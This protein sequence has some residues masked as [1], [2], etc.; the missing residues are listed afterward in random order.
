MARPDARAVAGYYAAPC[1]VAESCARMVGHAVDMA[2]G[3]VA[4]RVKASW[5]MVDPCAANGEAALTLL[6]ALCGPDLKGRSGAIERLYACEL[7]E[8]RHTALVQACGAAFGYG[9]QGRLLHGDAFRVRC[10]VDDTNV[11]ASILWLNP[12]YDQRRGGV[13]PES[14]WLDRWT[15]SLVLGGILFF[16]VPHKALAAC[17]ATLATHYDRL[18]CFRFPDATFPLFGQ[19]VVVGVRRAALPRP[20]P[21]V[22]AMVGRWADDPSALCD[23]LQAPAGAYPLRVVGD[24]DK[25]SDGDELNAGF[26][27]WELRGL[28]LATVVTHFTPWRSRDR[29]GVETFMRGVLPETGVAGLRT[30]TFSTAMPLCE[31][32]VAAALACN[33]YDGV[34]LTPNTPG[35]GKPPVFAKATGTRVWAET[36]ARQNDDGEDVAIERVQQPHLAITALDTRAGRIIRFPSTIDEQSTDDIGAMSAAD[37]VR[38]YSQA[39][40]R[41]LGERCVALYDP[42]NEAHKTERP[43]VARPLFAAQEDRAMACVRLLDTHRCALLLGATGTG[44]T[45][46]AAGVISALAARPVSTRRKRTGA[47]RRVLVVCPP[48]LL[49]SWTSELAIVAPHVRS[50]V[51]DSI[52]AAE[53]FARDPGPIVGIVA[54]TMSKLEHARAGFGEKVPFTM[55]GDGHGS[56][57]GSEHRDTFQHGDKRARETRERHGRHLAGRPCARCGAEPTLNPGDLANKRA[58][59]KATTLDARNEA[60]RLALLLIDAL[61]PVWPD[62]AEIVTHI[63]VQHRHRQRILGAWE[64]AALSTKKPVARQA[65]WIDRRK[66]PVLRAIVLRLTR[67]LIRAGGDAPKVQAALYAL[68]VGLADDALTSDAACRLWY[69]AACEPYAHRAQRLRDVVRGV[70]LLMTPCSEAQAMLAVSLASSVQ[71]ESPPCAVTG[72]GGWRS[73]A[74]KASA[75]AGAAPMMIEWWDRHHED[76][77]FSAWT[78]K[79]GAPCYDGLPFGSAKHGLNALTHLLAVARFTESAPCDEPL[80]QSIPQPRR[81]PLG[82]YLAHRHR[83]AID[84][85]IVDEVHRN[86]KMDSAQSQAMAWFRGRPMLCMTGSFGNGFAASMFHVLYTISASFRAEFPRGKEGER[87][88][89]RKCGFVRQVVEDRD[90]G[91]GAV[92]A[93]GTQSSRV[94]RKARTV[95]DAPGLVPTAILQHILPV[96]VVLHMADLNV[97]I[98]Y[99]ERVHVVDMLPEQEKRYTTYRDKLMDQIAK[100]RRTKKRGA[101]FGAMGEVWG[102]PTVAIAGCGNSGSGLYDARYPERHGGDVVAS[103]PVMPGEAMLPTERVLIERLRANLDAGRNTIIFAW[104]TDSGLFQRLARLIEAETGEKCPVLLSNMVKTRDREKWLR[105]E[106]VGKARVLLVNPACV[107]TGLNVLTWFSRVIWHELPGCNAN[108]LHQATSR[109]HRLGQPLDVLVEW[110]LYARTAQQHLH[111]LVL[112]KLAEIQSVAGADPRAALMASGVGVQEGMSTYDLGRALYRIE[113]KARG[114]DGDV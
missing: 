37:F 38:E 55:L 85:V 51:V 90:E 21:S 60:A 39:L 30:P 58:R 41:V 77:S 54:D 13:R 25:D 86:G 104:H 95:G 62:A 20:A 17:A 12:P 4:D 91:T 40:Y 59:C 114:E 81:V 34:R 28:D 102:A 61:G 107:E 108:M 10:E 2:G 83:R 64:A 32:H 33:V 97:E 53:T 14:A 49:D 36:G 98:P 75:L 82:R 72:H 65:R 88:F 23:V 106:I 45:S 71:G 29:R 52:D 47:A 76:H 1:D 110:I 101:L 35:P 94:V 50:M 68:L 18:A 66:T 70:V 113:R 57:E 22:V 89:V 3:V 105:S 92:V 80:Y 27:K 93:Y 109:V 43:S 78:R 7:E 111:R 8:T 26:A 24:E 15:P 19:V 31:G 9:I 63:P 103:F 69:G 56:T 79:D 6:R 67:E 48:I 84:L 74:R 46:I 44:K 42:E 87:E 5:A 96:A 112:L 16:V 99:E 73:M 11:G 100:D